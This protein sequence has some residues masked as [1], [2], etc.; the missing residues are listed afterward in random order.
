LLADPNGLGTNGFGEDLGIIG[1][2]AVV[3]DQELSFGSGG[4]IGPAAFLV[5]KRT[6][7]Q[8]SLVSRVGTKSGKEVFGYADFVLEA[9]SQLPEYALLLPDSFRLLDGLMRNWGG[10]NPVAAANWAFSLDDEQSKGHALAMLNYT[11]RA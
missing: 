6:G 5:L 1:D 3:A 8:W 10:L 7:T 4:K 11:F 2:I 9:L